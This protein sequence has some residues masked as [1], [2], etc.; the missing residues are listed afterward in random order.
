MGQISKLGWLIGL[1]RQAMWAEFLYFLYVLLVSIST[2]PF[3]PI[4]YPSWIMVRYEGKLHSDGTLL[5]R[6]NI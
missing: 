6:S 1:V 5:Y 3:Q 4:P 2:I